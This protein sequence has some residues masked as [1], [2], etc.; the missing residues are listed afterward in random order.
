LVHRQNDDPDVGMLM[1]E[2]AC[3][4]DAVQRVSILTVE[5]HEFRGPHSQAGTI[6][7]GT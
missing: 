5:L 3:G 7:Y 6:Q 1:L 2:L 4:I